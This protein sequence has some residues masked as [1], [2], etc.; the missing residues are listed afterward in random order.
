[1]AGQK[2]DRNKDHLSAIQYLNARDQFDAV[3]RS[4]NVILQS[5]GGEAKRTTPETT[6]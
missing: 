6:T 1:M 2:D 3:D 4:I 5:I